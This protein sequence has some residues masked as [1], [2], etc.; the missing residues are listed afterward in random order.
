MRVARFL[1]GGV[2]LL[3]ALVLAAAW[4][5]PPLL[6][7]GRYRDAIATLASDR[8]GR[9]VRIA[10]PVSLTLLPEP[11]LTA[12][13]VSLT[14]AGDGIAIHAAQLHLRV[15][16]LAL[17]AGKIDAEELA[18][19]GAEMHVP[20]PFR[21]I[22][23]AA[24]APL[25]FAAASVHI[26][27]GRLVIGSLAFT[28]VRATL[29]KDPWTGSFAAAG[30][31]Q[32]STR[33]WHFTVRLTRA[34][35]D[36]SAGL[37][38]S[39]DGRGP[40]Q[41]TGAMVS[42]QI[43][44]DGTFGGRVTGRGT[45]LSQLL[46]APAVPFTAAAR[47]SVAGGRATADD[48]TGD[49]GGSPVKGVATLRASP[50][51]RLDLALA[52]SRLDLDTWLPAV[53][54]G[55]QA[56]LPLGIDISAE[57]AQLAGGTL[58]QVRGGF[59]FNGT[60]IGV[61]DVHAVLPGDASLAAS[62]QAQRGPA[63]FEGDVALSAPALRTTLAWLESAGVAPA[64]TLPEAVLRSAE[65]TARAVLEPGQLTLTALD[66]RT[67]A[68]HLSGSLGVHVGER[69]TLTA[70]LQADRLELDRW[71]P[72]VWPPLA[73]IPSRLDRMDAD[74]RL[75]VRE[76]VLRGAPF[77][78]VSLDGAVSGG[79]VKLRRLELAG[80]P[81]RAAVSGTL[82]EGGRIGDGRIDI[83]VPSTE[84]MGEALPA[85]FAALR[86]MA[87]FWRGPATLSLQAAGP[88]EALALRVAGEL[89]DLRLE[90]Q[91]LLDLRA[92][93][94]AGVL[95]L[96]HPG[97]PRLAESLGLRGVPSWLGDGSLGLVAQL[98]VQL[99]S[100]Q[101]GAEQP[102]RVAAEPFDLAAGGLRAGGTLVLDGIDDPAAPPRLSGRIVADTLPLPLPY[103]RSPEP[104]PFEALAGWQAR[105]KLEAAHVLAGASPVLQQ[106]VATLELADGRLRIDG[107]SAQLAEGALTGSASVAVRRTG[108]RDGAPKA[109]SGDEVLRARSPADAIA[110]GPEVAL[111]VQLAGAVLTEPLFDLPVDIATGRLDAA[112]SFTASGHSPAA[113]LSTLTGEARLILSDGTVAGV[114]LG[115]A[116]GALPDA[117]VR[118][119]LAGGTTPFTRI[120]LVLRA[121]R[122]LLQVTDGRMT[123]LS[124]AARLGGSVDLAG[125]TAEL[126]LGLLPAVADP[127]EIGIVLAGPL[128]ALRRVPDLT[129]VARWR[130]AH[131]GGR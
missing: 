1:F 41:G 80:G 27:D 37:D 40:V 97:A 44:G 91:P 20:W 85:P 56:L 3:L 123:G 18:L 65:L 69:P 72:A 104:L 60:A 114:A 120:E 84:A 14:D 33:P 127:P 52:A 93:R 49:I 9:E 15:A 113:L 131:A 7:W 48:L 119:A 78:P 55:G 102:G 108:A 115:K 81:V 53:L 4:L 118:A 76:V 83:Q 66:G 21:P 107:L 51:L 92:R 98:A 63:R 36:G 54:R 42:G 88:P 5:L 129:A 23:I 12:S 10:G 106:A 11:V 43:H 71:L 6:D 122:G 61:H 35:R 121:R 79:Q 34:G 103:P 126:S 26:E 47:V 87:R 64:D 2:V 89:G 57:A 24:G 110:E 111:D 117:A 45:D 74:L 8:L 112:M 67:D 82:A 96:R 19:R 29:S 109:G 130:A 70:V 86:D 95:T 13:D 59:D 30:T 50:A 99:P 25:W 46:P 101:A 125:N 22:Q 68:T 58:R 62:G 90:A 32:L 39:L 17:A 77:G 73:A 31:L 116:D 38:A 128:D 16:L 105:V 100:T 124:G 94:A 75:G 28:G